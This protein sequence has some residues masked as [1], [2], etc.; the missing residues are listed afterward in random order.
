MGVVLVTTQIEDGSFNVRSIA[1]SR[2]TRISME[3]TSEMELESQSLYYGKVC[4]LFSAIIPILTIINQPEDL[5]GALDDFD[6]YLLNHGINDQLASYITQYAEEKEEMV[7]FFF[8]D[9]FIF[10]N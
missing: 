10:I 9:L 1:H 3:L 6:A 4:N 8:I 2:N 7:Y 5:G